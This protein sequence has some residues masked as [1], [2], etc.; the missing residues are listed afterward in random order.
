MRQL[1]VEHVSTRRAGFRQHPCGVMQTGCPHQLAIIRH[2]D[3]TLDTVGA[4]LV[5][6]F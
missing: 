4:E 3:R 5:Y 2:E 1:L 6:S